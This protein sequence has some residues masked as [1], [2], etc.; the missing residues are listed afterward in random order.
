MAT[1][2]TTIV[3]RTATAGDEAD[4][5]R[6]AV[7]DGAGQVPSDSVLVAE[8]GG[9]I[10][11]AY[12]IEDGSYVADPFWYSAELVELMRIHAAA[13]STPVTMRRRRF[14]RGASLRVPAFAGGR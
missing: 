12:G 9:R 13:M 1:K 4:I 8:A 10:R 6:V 2:D 3:I 11:A 7:L 14:G 5:R